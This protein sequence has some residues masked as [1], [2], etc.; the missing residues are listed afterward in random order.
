MMR[1]LL[2]LVLCVGGCAGSARSVRT[3]ADSPSGRSL[4]VVEVSEAKHQHPAEVSPERLRRAMESGGF[5]DP[6]D[7]LAFGPQAAELFGSLK[8][9]Q[10][11]AIQAALG[12]A[13][14]IHLFVQTGELKMQRM[15]GSTIAASSSYPLGSPKREQSQANV[16]PGSNGADTKEAKPTPGP[17]TKVAVLKLFAEDGIS[18]SIRNLATDALVAEMTK[19]EGLE[20]IGSSDVEAM[21]GFEKQKDLLGCEENISC[22]AEIGGALGVEKIVSGR[23]GKVGALLLLNLGLIN[24]AD[25]RPENRVTKRHR[26]ER[27]EDFFELIGPACQELMRR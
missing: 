6:Q 14:E 23:M 17:R 19:M 10:R 11:L 20:V 21:L 3:V 27:L 26:S 13:V 5:F 12:E 4:A 1:T 24:I 8:P 25:A 15:F 16:A 7:V 18:D 2:G 22:L 9:N